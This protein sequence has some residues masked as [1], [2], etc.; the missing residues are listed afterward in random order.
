MITNDTN[1]VIDSWMR[2]YWKG[3]AKKA[4]IPGDVYPK[5]QRRRVEAIL[6]EAQVSIAYEDS[7][8]DEI[9]GYIVVRPY[10]RVVDYVYVK[11]IY[12]RAG[13]ASGL[14]GAYNV[15]FYSHKTEWEGC[16]A[17]FRGLRYNP[18]LAE[19]TR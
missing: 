7:V 3:W 2:S 18:Y 14:L 6:F 4:G 16:E 11:S 5:E 8:P 1:F 12:R 15:E 9:F 17:L 10:K 13:I 19:P